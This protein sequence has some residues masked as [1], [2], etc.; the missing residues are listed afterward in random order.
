M[1]TIFALLVSCIRLFAADDIG[2]TVTTKTNAD[3]GAVIT[4]Q[5]FTRAG[6]TNLLSKTAVT[7]GV[8]QSRFYRFYHDGKVAADHLTVPGDGYVLIVTHNG[9]DMSFQSCSNELCS[10]LLHDK[11]DVL[12]DEFL[13]TNGVLAPIPSS[14]LRRVSDTS[15]ILKGTKKDDP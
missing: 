15:K 1:K 4:S 2:L 10:V 13:G 3:T 11:D 6:Q 14:D 8:I 5:Y 9:F 12:L 7:N